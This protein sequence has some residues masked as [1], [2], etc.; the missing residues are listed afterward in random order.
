VNQTLHSRYLTIIPMAGKGTRALSLTGYGATPKSFINAAARGATVMEEIVREA[1]DSGLTELTIIVTSDKDQH[2]FETFFRPFQ[3]DPSLEA[4]LM[5]K[6]LTRDLD[7]I[8]ELSEIEV[9]FTT[10]REP[11]GF[12]DAVGRA[13]PHMQRM[14]EVGHPY[15][16]A[17]VML[18]DDL[19][20][21]SVPCAKQVISAYEASGSMVLALQQVSRKQ[22]RHYGVVVLDTE[23]PTLDL[24][25][26]FCGKTAYRILDVEE[27]PEDPH[28]NL[29][30]GEERYYAIL[31]RYVLRQTDVEY[32]HAG[33]GTPDME[34]D[35]TG[36]FKRNAAEG[37][38]IGVEINGEWWTVGNSLEAQL[39]AIRY[40]LGQYGSPGDSGKE[41]LKLS[42][43]TLNVLAR[44]GAITEIKPGIFRV[45][46]DVV[47]AMEGEK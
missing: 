18:G 1:E 33:E 26:H 21:S 31:G 43:H 7:R 20:H 15:K 16:G 2:A 17:V 12:G 30:D 5:R 8:R 29:I 19:I 40:F 13:A 22:S 4:H 10:Q 38:L 3:I 32:L 34:L 35:F 44:V 6:G 39:T 36:L 42:A 25:P 46:P 27:K 28:P 14:A 11:K 23:H 45:A 41:G 37:S 24:G 47:Q 9:H